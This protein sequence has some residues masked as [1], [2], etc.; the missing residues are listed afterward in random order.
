MGTS[1]S[2]ENHKKQG[3]M[4]VD[5]ATAAAAFTNKI[6]DNRVSFAEPPPGIATHPQAG[7]ASSLVQSV[8]SGNARSSVW[9]LP[10]EL[11]S[12]HYFQDHYS[13]L[14]PS[15]SVRFRGST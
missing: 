4:A 3:T 6:D 12:A 9:S 8:G 15:S 11:V 7:A 5:A 2:T 14:V 10:T 1:A 13:L